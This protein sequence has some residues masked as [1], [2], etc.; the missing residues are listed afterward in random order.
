VIPLRFSQPRRWRYPLNDKYSWVEFEQVA[1]PEECA[2]RIGERVVVA[3]DVAKGDIIAALLRVDQEVLEP[4]RTSG[5]ALEWQLRQE[6]IALY[7]VSPKRVHEAC[8]GI[9]RGAELA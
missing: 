8:G 1:W 3:V 5:D 4:S 7:R 6:G 2:R 9:R